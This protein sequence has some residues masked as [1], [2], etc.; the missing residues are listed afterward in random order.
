ML[1]VSWTSSS[2]SANLFQRARSHYKS[3][4]ILPKFCC[5]RFSSFVAFWAIL[6]PGKFSQKKSDCI[7]TE[8][9]AYINGQEWRFFTKKENWKRLIHVTLNVTHLRERP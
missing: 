9:V 3:I 1:A 8:G 2:L 4:L 5:L 6:L 7:K